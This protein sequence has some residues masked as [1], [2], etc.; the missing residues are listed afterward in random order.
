MLFS[1]RGFP[2]RPYSDLIL[3]LYGPE[4]GMHAR[5]SIHRRVL[6]GPSVLTFSSHLGRAMVPGSMDN[7]R[8]T[9]LRAYE[10][11][12]MEGIIGRLG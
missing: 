11:E 12:E 2:R 3:E 10:R 1:L 7:L 4:V 9:T 6:R 5:S 8:S